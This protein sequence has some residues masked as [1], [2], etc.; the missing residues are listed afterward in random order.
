MNKSM[1]FSLQDALFIG[2][3]AT[4]LVALKSMLRLKLGLSGHSMFL[5]TFFYLICYG[6]VGRLGAITACGVL[7]GLVAMVLSIGKGGP[8]ILLKFAI[9][10]LAMDMS[11]IV[12]T[13]L[14]TL[15]W[16]CITV[17]LVGCLAW[18]M[19]G[20]VEDLLVGMT[21]QVALVQL[22]LSMLKGGVFTVLAASLVPPVLERL[23]SH[24]LFGAN[25]NDNGK[26]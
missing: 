15:R 6:I 3:C 18:A 11:L 14:F 12:L 21:M 19:K 16:R 5:M 24:D 13:G 10:A 20:W 23:K 26:I 22:G 25:S 2:F 4:L 1:S 8:L 17:G 7:S 9:P